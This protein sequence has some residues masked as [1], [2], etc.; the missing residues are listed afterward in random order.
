MTLLHTTE[1]VGAWQLFLPTPDRPVQCIAVLAGDA[2]YGGFTSR[3]NAEWFVHRA[4]LQDAQVVLYP[5]GQPPS[6]PAP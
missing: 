2:R 1:A 5:E 6:S 3:E 4:G